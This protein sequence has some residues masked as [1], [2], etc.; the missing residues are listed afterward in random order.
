MAGT[1][2]NLR[3]W[4]I[5]AAA[6]GVVA[7]A[8]LIIGFGS[9]H[10]TTKAEITPDAT[11]SSAST[12]PGSPFTSPGASGPGATASGRATAASTPTGPTSP[13]TASSS[14]PRAGATTTVPVL[15]P[16]TSGPAQ[17]VLTFVG[18][19]KTMSC[20][21]APVTCDAQKGDDL[22]FAIHSRPWSSIQSVCLTFHFKGD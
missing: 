15:T 14:T 7:V 20:T 4:W 5:A 9:R 8:I 18:G 22:K 12:R 10:S 16:T 17:P 21:T 13:T 3:R 19:N 1:K 6:V 11:S 2:P